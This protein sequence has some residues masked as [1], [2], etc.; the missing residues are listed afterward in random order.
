MRKQTRLTSPE[1]NATTITI[2]ELR[3]ALNGR[4]IAPDAAGYDE[5]R[6]VFYGGIDRR[7]AVIIRVASA[8][9]V[10]QVVSLAHE[11]GL[12]LAV[13]SG[14]HSLAGNSTTDGGIVLDLSDMKALQIDTER[15][16]AWAETGLTAGEYTAVAGAHGLAT[17]FGDTGS[18]GIGGITL[19]GGVGYFVRKYG[20]TIDDLLA[21]DVVTADGRLLRV[22]AETHPD[23]FWA[24]RGGGGNFGVATR[25]RFRLHEVD[26]IVGGMLLLPATPDVIESFAAEAEAAPEELSAIANIMPAPPVPFV[27]AEHHGRP[28]IMAMLVYAGEVEAGEP[29]ITP[30]PALPTPQAPDHGRPWRGL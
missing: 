20:L 5:A 4:V 21:A 25:F 9:D 11:T 3:A 12:N 6:A 1:T 8:A 15:R 13:R 14:G 23:F 10:S 17:G 16:T 22:D 30:L 19:G 26:T 2:P 27:P 7:P 28:V 24:I 29:A 18:V